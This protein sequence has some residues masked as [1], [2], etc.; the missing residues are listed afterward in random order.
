MTKARFEIDDELPAFEMFSTR[1]EK[2]TFVLLQVCEMSSAGL[3]LV[4]VPE[5]SVRLGNVETNTLD[6]LPLATSRLLVVALPLNGAGRLLA[7]VTPR[8]V[9]VVGELVPNVI[10]LLNA[11]ELVKDSALVFVGPITTLFVP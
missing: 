9:L 1:P 4:I 3:L 2:V 5:A 6:P 8:F 7:T 10:G 11:T